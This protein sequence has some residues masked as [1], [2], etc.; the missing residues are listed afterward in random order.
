MFRVVAVKVNVQSP[1]PLSHTSRASRSL[2][3]F[4][5]A[6]SWTLWHHCVGV[7]EMTRAINNRR[8]NQKNRNKLAALAKK[9][10]KERLLLG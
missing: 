9:A 7:C 8:R 4:A 3:R 2:S 6:T 1:L 10:K 5:T